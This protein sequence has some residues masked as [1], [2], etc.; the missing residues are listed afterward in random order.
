MSIP[1]NH[2]LVVQPE[3]RARELTWDYPENK[4]VIGKLFL[5][6]LAFAKGEIIDK[7]SCR[8]SFVQ[9]IRT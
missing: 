9:I 7:V 4:K 6:P 2:R 8:I 3:N 5:R 1:L